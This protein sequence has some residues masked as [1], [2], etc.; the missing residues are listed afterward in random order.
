MFPRTVSC[1]W[2]CETVADIA[3][4]LSVTELGRQRVRRGGPTT[5]F[6]GSGALRRDP[7]QAVVSGF[8]VPVGLRPAPS[9]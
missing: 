6:T 9:S 8:H 2:L 7:V 5:G 4:F 3:S 1:H